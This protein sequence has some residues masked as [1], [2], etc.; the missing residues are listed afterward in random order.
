MHGYTRAHTR[1][2]A[3]SPGQ[4]HSRALMRTHG[5]T[6]IH[7]VQVERAEFVSQHIFG[8]VSQFVPLCFSNVSMGGVG[9]KTSQWFEAEDGDNAP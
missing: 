1:M 6:R 7:I 5:H 4:M 9:V 2:H 3:H 8:C